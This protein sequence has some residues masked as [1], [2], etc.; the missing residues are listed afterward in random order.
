MESGVISCTRWFPGKVLANVV[1]AAFCIVASPFFTKLKI[2]IA[3]CDFAL[4]SSDEVSHF[5][6]ASVG[7]GFLC[8]ALR[9][10]TVTFRLLFWDFVYACWF[11]RAAL[12]LGFLGDFVLIY[13]FGYSVSRLRFQGFLGDF[14]SVS[15][16][17]PDGF[18]ASNQV[19]LC[20]ILVG[21][22]NVLGG[23]NQGYSNFLASV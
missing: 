17:I 11:K 13:G 19:L 9:C 2:M 1:A 20:G 3:V 10:L 18:L 8:F 5:T 21:C 23:Q 12:V 22:F 6:V 4:F 16:A 15:L 14:G 7:Y